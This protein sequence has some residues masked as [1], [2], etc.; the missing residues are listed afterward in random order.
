MN[1]RFM[2]NIRSDVNQTLFLKSKKTS[3]EVVVNTTVVANGIAETNYTTS[4]AGEYKLVRI[5]TF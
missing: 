5:F 2:V 3:K 4:D 1:S